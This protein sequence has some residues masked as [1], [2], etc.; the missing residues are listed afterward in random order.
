MYTKETIEKLIGHK[1]L[2]RISYING[3]DELTSD[4]GVIQSIIRDA[5]IFEVKDG[6]IDHG[7]KKVIYFRYI[8]NIEA[9]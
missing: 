4:S 9:P 8:K 6:T 7:R 1:G 3:D 5:M 2:L